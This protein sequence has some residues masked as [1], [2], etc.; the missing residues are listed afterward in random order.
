M[1]TNK[2]AK[3]LKALQNNKKVIVKD[4]Y[5]MDPSIQSLKDHKFI[6]F[7]LGVNEDG[8]YIVENVFI[9]SSGFVAL[10]KFNDDKKDKR[11][12]NFFYPVLANIVYALS[13]FIA[14][15]VL[16]YLHFK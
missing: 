11:W 14:G 10:D 9:E 7:K 3:I 13:G 4:F 2:Q 6:S 16:T 12:Q 8:D 1:I 5:K 15:V